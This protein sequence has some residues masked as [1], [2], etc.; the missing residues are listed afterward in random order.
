M[1]NQ[2][3]QSN[4]RELVES[5][6][7]ILP[8][9][10]QDDFRTL[11]NEIVL[12]NLTSLSPGGNLLRPGGAPQGS[13]VAPSGV[14]FAVIGANGT[15]SISIVD[16]PTA[17]PNTIWHEI[18]YSPL[19]SFTKEVVTLPATTGLAASI[20]AP[21][22]SAYFRLRSSFDK[23]TWSGYQLASSSI[24]NAGLIESPAIASGATFNQTNFALVNSQAYQGAAAIT[25]SGTGGEFTNYPAIK[26]TVQSIRPSATIVGVQP[27][28]DQFVGWDG[29]QFQTK[30]TLAAVLANN[31]EPVGKAS[32]VSSAA[33]RLPTIQPIGVA[34]AILGFQI[35]DGGE[36]AS[37]PYT[38]DIEDPGGPGNG[39]T[40]GPQTI[41]NGVLISIAPGNPGNSY[42]GNT[43][44]TASGG[45]GGGTG[46]GT[47]VGG[48]GGRMTAV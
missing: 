22:N 26:G 10:A 1:A 36:G 12:E 42:D 37:Q 24:I 14:T 23:K 18:S 11:L 44:V 46:G 6:A 7:R 2:V 38:I 19:V 21:G 33:P 20:P 41:Q 9:K 8:P 34:G 47:A 32:V 29:S 15:F 16:P 30:P 3:I 48:N 43:T 25:V 27:G 40:A 28:T 45:Q 4:P 39:A 31:L 13:S 35:I 17:K 5:V